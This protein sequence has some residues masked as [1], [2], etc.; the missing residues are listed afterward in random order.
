M[1]PGDGQIVINGRQP[2][3]YFSVK[4]WCEEM[5]LALV[6]A[7]LDGKFDITIVTHGGGVHGQSGAARLGIGRALVNYDPALPPLLRRRGQL[8]RDPRAKERKKYG[9]KGARKK[10]QWTKR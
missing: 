5:L 2:A 4:S 3:N 9:Q 8:T 6:A 7:Q 10:F 1:R